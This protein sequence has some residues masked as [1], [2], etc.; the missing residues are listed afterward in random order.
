MSDGHRKIGFDRKLD[1]EWL[2]AAAGRLAA[3]DAPMAARHQVW[4][5]LEG[6]LSGDASNSARGKTMTVLTQIWMTAPTHQ[7]LRDAA[8]AIFGQVSPDERLALHWA[9]TLAAYPFFLD[10]AAQTGKLLRLNGD[11]TFAQIHR[12]MMERWGERST[13]SR[14]VQRVLRSMVA[15]GALREGA[16]PGQYQPLP[17]RIPVLEATAEIVLEGL[18]RAEGGSLALNAVATHPALFPFDLHLDLPRLRQH[19]RLWVHRQGD[20][21][22]W[23]ELEPPAAH[24]QRQGPAPRFGAVMV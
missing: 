18:L 12:R 23:V 3:G 16:T 11:C 9:M 21:T 7:P 13:L 22:D 4:N 19:P 24:R 6:I 2:D 8:L 15:W 20:Q 10:V 5:R 14:A 1:L 17:K